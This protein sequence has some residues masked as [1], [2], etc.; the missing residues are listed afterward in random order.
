MDILYMQTYDDMGVSE[1]GD[2]PT[3][4]VQKHWIWL[5]FLV[6]NLVFKCDNCG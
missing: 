4:L 5:V 3:V 6:A 2:N 1:H